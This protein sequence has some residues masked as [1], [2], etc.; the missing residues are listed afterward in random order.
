MGRKE[1]EVRM[2]LAMGEK[3]VVEGIRIY[4]ESKV[5]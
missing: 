3:G 5:V 2:E 1:G 4:S